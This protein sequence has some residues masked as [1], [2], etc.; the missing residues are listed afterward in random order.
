M[1]ASGD[2]PS[3]GCFLTKGTV[4]IVRLVHQIRLNLLKKIRATFVARKYFVD[5][6]TIFV[7]FTHC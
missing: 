4:I 6:E 5:T 7:L 3:T 2:D 1:V